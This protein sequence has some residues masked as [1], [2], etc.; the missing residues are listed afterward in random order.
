MIMLVDCNNF[1]ASCERVFNPTLRR[2][3]VIILSPN[4]GCIVSRSNEAKAL[5]VPMGAPIF[6]IKDLVKTH[7]I[8]VHSSN[9]A[10]YGDLSDRV[11][12]IIASMFP[13]IEYYS[14]DEAFLDV[15]EYRP[16]QLESLAY[17]LRDTIQQW[18]GIPVSVGIA[19]TKVLAKVASK[20]AKKN[21]GV[22]LLSDPAV[23]TENLAR[24]PVED[25]W[26][27]GH[28]YA[29]KLHAMNIRT[30]LEFRSLPT[31]WLKKNMTVNG[32]RIG[33]ELM[34]I[35]CIPVEQFK[36]DRKAIGCARGFG[37]TVTTQSEL[38]EALTS[39]VSSCAE[40][41]RN[42]K[43]AATTVS[44]FL[45]TNFFNKNERQY[46]N[47]KT[48]PFSEPTN[49]TPVILKYASHILRCIYQPGFKYKR[50]GILLSGFVPAN[51]IQQ[52]LFNRIDGGRLQQAQKTIDVINRKF[53]R[54]QV[55]F[56]CQ[57]F[58]KHWQMKQ[59][60]LSPR[61][62]TCLKEILTVRL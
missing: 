52:H 14:V 9:F 17:R 59:E 7:S 44:V 11:M 35:P 46:S 55:R 33:M 62:T 42:Q 57:G 48:I 5:G 19:P 31:T 13:E 20:I 8:S 10:L 29:K 47:F 60:K 34:A 2:K 6:E 49:L 25:L 15:S 38:K 39:Y 51:T 36:K 12:K 58:T 61:Y 30:A 26:G 43:S 22:L 50:V 32:L 4:D 23:I 37:T 21:T 54:D 40:K 1:Y 27:V 41:L 28:R 16:D 18:V 3:P 45:Q 53:Q 24:F 56:A